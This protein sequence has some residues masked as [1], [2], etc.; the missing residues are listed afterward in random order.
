[1]ISYIVVFLFYETFTTIFLFHNFRFMQFTIYKYN[2][3]VLEKQQ[4]AR[5]IVYLAL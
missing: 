4:R 3:E 1:M 2:V 5:Y